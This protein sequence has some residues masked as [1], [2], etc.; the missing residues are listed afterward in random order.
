MNDKRTKCLLVKQASSTCYSC[1][2]VCH[3]NLGL[4][5]KFIIGSS[6]NLYALLKLLVKYL[7]IVDNT[8]YIYHFYRI[9]KFIHEGKYR[10]MAK[11]KTL[12]ALEQLITNS[13]LWYFDNRCSRHMTRDSIVF[14][15]FSSHHGRSI[16][17]GDNGKCMIMSK[18][19]IG[20]TSS[21]NNVCF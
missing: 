4:E 17:F 9:R 1:N 3:A 6:I 16:T 20:K 15:T 11:V 13:I 14:F 5:V 12:V 10:W 18:G 8:G 7:L 19:E 2:K 21:I